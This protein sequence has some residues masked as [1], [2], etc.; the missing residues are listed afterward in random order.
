MSRSLA[1]K[2]QALQ[3]PLFAQLTTYLIDSRSFPAR[4]RMIEEGNAF[5][6]NARLL[7]FSGLESLQLC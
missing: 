1:G 7:R 4:E 6:G 2:R 3:W 5:Y